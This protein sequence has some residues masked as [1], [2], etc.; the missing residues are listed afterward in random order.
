MRHRQFLPYFLVNL[1]LGTFIFLY[2]FFPLSFTSDERAHF[3]DLP[4]SI[5]DVP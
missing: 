5:D 2:G 3:N 4:E 1:L